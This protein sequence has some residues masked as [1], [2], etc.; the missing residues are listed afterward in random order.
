MQRRLPIL[1]I[2]LL[3]ACTAD[4][5]PAEGPVLTDAGLYRVDATPTPDPPVA[6]D[7]AL[8]LLLSVAES[9]A[10]VTGAA[11]AVEPWMPAMNHGIMGEVTVSET[12]E[13]HYHA[14]WAYSMPGWWEVT[15]TVDAAE[16]VDTVTLGYEV[17]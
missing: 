7:A 16:G 2:L 10:P 6:G 5:D 12:G 13:G 11:L 15:L 14:E 17:E 1:A 3:V 8:H 4:G 9:D